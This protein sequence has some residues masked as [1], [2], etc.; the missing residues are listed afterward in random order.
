MFQSLFQQSVYIPRRTSTSDDIIEVP[1]PNYIIIP[2]EYPERINY[3]PLVKVGDKV[4]GNQIIGRSELGNC[5]HASV[6]G[7]V[8][9]I[10]S[11]WTFRSHYVPALLIERNDDPFYSVEDIYEQY[12]LA[13]DKASIQDK[14]RVMGVLSPWSRTGRF[15]REEDVS[16]PE[17]HKIIVKG[18]NEEPSVFIFEQLL[19]KYPDKIKAGFNYLTELTSDV[20]INL[21]VPE[22]DVKWAKDTFDSEVNIVGLSDN[23]PDRIEPMVV[24]GLT[25]LDI[26]YRESYRKYGVAVISSEYLLNLVDALEGTTPFIHKY[27]SIAGSGIEKAVTVKYPI[28]TPIRYVLRGANLEE[29]N[30]PRIVVGGPMKGIAQYSPLMPLTKSGHG[31]YLFSEDDLPGKANA[32]CITCGKCTRACPVKLQ[33]HLIARYAEF[34]LFEEARPFHPEA[35]NECGICGYV[36]PAQRSLVQWIQLC[37]RNLG[38]S[39]E[40]ESKIECSPKSSLEEWDFHIQTAAGDFARY[41]ASHSG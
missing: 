18:V 24:A 32:A 36:C 40:Y 14:L 7:V 23:Y 11:V 22:K 4:R 26:P 19:K 35:C 20:K 39:Y 16:Y 31:L 28:G 25:K 15:H 34:N 5:V 17:I 33:V 12:G 21:I 8:R 38:M 30:Y 10:L 1:V 29:E 2:L 9:D 3:K 13:I 37:K 41:A 27:S 6:S